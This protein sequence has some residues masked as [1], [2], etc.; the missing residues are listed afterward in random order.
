MEWK[1]PI[2]ILFKVHAHVQEPGTI[3]EISSTF[4]LIAL[5]FQNFYGKYMCK[6][7]MRGI[8]NGKILPEDSKDFWKEFDCSR[9]PIS[10]Y[11]S[12]IW[13]LR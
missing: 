2:W 10:E 13:T 9:N 3:Q 4:H 7:N 12:A 1:R 11:Q 6:S 8:H 5:C